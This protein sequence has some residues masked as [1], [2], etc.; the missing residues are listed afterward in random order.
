MRAGTPPLAGYISQRVFS[1]ASL[2]LLVV[3]RVRRINDT[4]LAR[5]STLRD[6]E[7]VFVG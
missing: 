1:S 2:A 5:A 7:E 6:R 4:V 3:V